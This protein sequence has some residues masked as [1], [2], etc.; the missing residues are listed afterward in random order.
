[1]L[2]GIYVCERE[3]EYYKIHVRETGKSFIME[4]IEDRGAL[5]NACFTGKYSEALGRNMDILDYPYKKGY[6]TSGLIGMLFGKNDD[7]STKKKVVVRKG[8]ITHGGYHPLTDWGNGS[9]TM[10]PFQAGQ[11]FVFYKE[12]EQTVQEAV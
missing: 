12:E 3:R 10:Y 8:K 9:F 2:N 11:P 5:C 7:G 6:D 1:M 4:M